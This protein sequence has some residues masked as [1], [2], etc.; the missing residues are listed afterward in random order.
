MYSVP[1]E[2]RAETVR[3][4]PSTKDILFV[5]VLMFRTFVCA[6]NELCFHLNFEKLS[7]QCKCVCARE[8]ESICVHACTDGVYIVS[9]LWV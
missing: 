3:V 2:Y 6:M 1:L 5:H 7:P 9:K 8:R 4:L